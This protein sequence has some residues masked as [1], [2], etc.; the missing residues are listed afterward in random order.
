MLLTIPFIYFWMKHFFPLNTL[1]RH[2][3]YLPGRIKFGLAYNDKEQWKVYEIRPNK[4]K[5]SQNLTQEMSLKGDLSETENG[6]P[7]EFFL[8]LMAPGWRIYWDWWNG[9]S[10][11]S[12][13][14]LYTYILIFLQCFSNGGV[15]VWK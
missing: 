11:G 13:F 15:Y 6:M 7:A 10:K 9:A 3:R 14:L 4:K 12:L 1:E 2:G 8:F 5:N